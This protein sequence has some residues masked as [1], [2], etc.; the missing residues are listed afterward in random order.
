VSKSRL[1]GKSVVLRAE[2]IVSLR[3]DKELLTREH[4]IIVVRDILRSD[5]L[6]GALE[7]P[8]IRQ[9]ILRRYVEGSSGGAKGLWQS[10]SPFF[11]PILLINASA[12][13]LANPSS[14]TDSSLPTT[15]TPHPFNPS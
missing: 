1:C 14:L 11:N 10:Q 5:K 12:I 9:A 7:A 15:A 13:A 6:D 8:N 2:V 3:L 4:R